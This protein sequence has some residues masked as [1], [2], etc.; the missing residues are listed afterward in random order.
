MN[1]FSGPIS[2]L[3][4]DDLYKEFYLKI[5]YIFYKIFTHMSQ[6][7]NALKTILSVSLCPLRI[8][9]TF[10]QFTILN[11][12]GRLKREQNENFDDITF[13]L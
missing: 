1:S 6:H 2:M 4:N 12:G 13:V 7:P 9:S 3:H 11:V 8:S 5:F 10:K